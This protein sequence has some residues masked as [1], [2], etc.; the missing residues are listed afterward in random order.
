MLRGAVISGKHNPLGLQN[1]QYLA[2]YLQ[3]GFDTYLCT[4]CL[5]DRDYRK[6]Q[7]TQQHL[8]LN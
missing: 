7:R 6:L 3:T 8:I 2:L 4:L 5:L 1:K